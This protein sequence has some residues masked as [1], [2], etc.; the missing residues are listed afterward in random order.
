MKAKI[1]L[2]LGSDRPDRYQTSGQKIGIKGHSDLHKLLP[3]DEPV[4]RLQLTPNY[5]RQSKR[6]ELEGYDCLLNLITEAEDND[7]VLDVLRKLARN[8]P[9]KLI[10][11]PEAV[12]RTTR[13]QIARRLGAV[14][15]LIVPKAIRLRGGRP[16]SAVKA[17]ERAG[18]D[19]PVILRKA[20]T[21]TGKFVGRFESM[22]PLV[23]ALDE[24]GDL[25]A[26]EFK[27]FR[28]DDGLYRKYRIFFIGTCP[29]L[30]HLLFLEDWNVHAK[31]G[32]DYKADRP[33][34]IE[35]ERRLMQRRGGAFPQQVIDTMAAV[36]Q[37]MGM[38]FFGID[39]AIAADGRPILFEANA[40]MNFF[41]FRPEPQFEYAKDCLG[42]AQQ[43]FRR[44]VGID[45]AELEPAS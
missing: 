22:D 37:A 9:G 10:N 19:F 26:T 45:T 15:G 25:I 1:L 40:T 23:G 8:L 13:D 43:A 17:I 42:P 32:E 4:H 36:Q 34:L 44:L 21:H 41:P 3:A 2:I 35:E 33:D 27:D 39:F 12:L 7:R 14:D 30:R 31:V 16:E 6:P 5:F 38:D 11:R 28:S 18:L 24:P 20:G 29:I